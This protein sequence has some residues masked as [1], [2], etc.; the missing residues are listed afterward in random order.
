[1]N[2]DE[3]S[4]IIASLIVRAED[5]EVKDVLRLYEI[6]T[7]T[8]ALKQ[9]L[10]SAKKGELV[11]T[12]NFLGVPEQA[13][14]NKPTVVYNLICRIQN[15]FPDICTVCKDSYTVDV[16][17][18]SILECALC[19]QSA[20]SPC[21]KA[22]LGIDPTQSLTAKEVANKINPFNIPDLHFF[23][24]ECSASTIPSLEPGK[25]NRP[26]RALASVQDDGTDLGLDLSQQ[27]PQQPR[28]SSVDEEQTVL[29]EPP[30]GPPP[31]TTVPGKTISTLSLAPPIKI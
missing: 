10:A 2:D 12:M 8:T 14:Y 24:K 26:R 13:N 25:L 16:E 18:I 22:L 31:P 15:L 29:K 30:V 19:G 4:T 28:E 11:K 17:E 3:K 6:N 1:M 27:P 7:T 23:C 9:K 5:D 21:I 20:H